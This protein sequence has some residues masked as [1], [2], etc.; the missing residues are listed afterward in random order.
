MGE[1]KTTIVIPTYNERENIKHLI[2]Q[3]F[4]VFKKSKIKGSVIVVDD[5]SPDGTAREAKKLSKKFPLKVIE[6]PSKQGLG[7]AYKAGFKEALNQKADIVFEMDADFSH[8]PEYIP[9]FLQK[10]AEG[11]DLVIGSRYMQGGKRESTWFNTLVGNGA[12][13]LVKNIGG[14]PVFDVTSG[15][16]AYNTRVFKKV[17]L[18]NL[19]S[20]GYEFQLEMVVR[21]N[22]EGFKLSEIPIVFTKRKFGDSKMSF[23]DIRRFFIY[24]V[25]MKLALV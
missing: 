25:K 1:L 14:L 10:L 3:V 18:E 7:T 13:F 19:T 16:R 6:R 5:N 2:P 20:K 4:Q 22:K 11:N 8:N 15:F 23:S 17:D 21:T 24:A 12:N 9:L